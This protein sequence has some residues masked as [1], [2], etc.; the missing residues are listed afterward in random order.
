MPTEQPA[1]DYSIDTLFLGHI[2]LMINVS[3]ASPILEI[4]S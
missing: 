4:K 2:K 1:K 3:H